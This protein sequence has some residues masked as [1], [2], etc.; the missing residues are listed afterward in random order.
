MGEML[1][2]FFDISKDLKSLIAQLKELNKHFSSLE[3]ITT[4][5]EGL[6]DELKDTNTNLSDFLTLFKDMSQR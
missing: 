4:T 3:K 6:K 1:Q 5:F 2:G